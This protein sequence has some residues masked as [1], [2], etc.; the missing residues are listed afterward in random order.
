MGDSTRRGFLAMAGMGAAAV[1]VGAA[2]PAAAG[3]QSGEL[4]GARSA[5]PL[6]AYVRDVRRHEIAVM[7]GEHEVVVHDRDLVN[8]LVQ[9]S[10]S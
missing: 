4:S 10:R 6:V 5:G 2:A 7:V 1:G 3:E 8:R 9:A